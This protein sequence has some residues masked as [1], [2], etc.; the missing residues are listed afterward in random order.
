[1]SFRYREHHVTAPRPPIWWITRLSRTTDLSRTELP[2]TLRQDLGLA[3]LIL[4]GMERG[5]RI[6]ALGGVAWRV[7]A[8]PKSEQEAFPLGFARRSFSA[9]VLFERF[10]IGLRS[11]GS[12]RGSPQQFLTCLRPDRWIGRAPLA[13]DSPIPATEGGRSPRIAGRL[14]PRLG[15]RLEGA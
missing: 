9:E 4:S 12:N 11:D 14:A 6:V 13:P 8:L 3:R 1:M 10:A 5:R 2:A 15:G 7:A